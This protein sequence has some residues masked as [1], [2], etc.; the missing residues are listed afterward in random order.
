M[1]HK[2]EGGLKCDCGWEFHHFRACD[3]WKV[4]LGVLVG[5][6]LATAVFGVW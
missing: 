1:D 3:I 5:L 6:L 4:L 2:K